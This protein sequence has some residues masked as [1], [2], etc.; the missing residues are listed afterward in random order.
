MPVVSTQ[1]AQ[2][3][4]LADNL[5]VG[6]A[7]MMV[8]IPLAV[9]G[10]RA[11]RVITARWWWAHCERDE[12]VQDVTLTRSRTA[13]LAGIFGLGLIVAAFVLYV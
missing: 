2:C 9:L 6:G 7:A 5:P 8:V 3:T 4:T 11:L 1:R 10:A 13:A 12:L